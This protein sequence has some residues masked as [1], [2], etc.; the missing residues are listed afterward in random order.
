MSEQKP[1][2]A[3]RRWGAQGPRRK[4]R[5]FLQ[6]AAFIPVLW[7]VNVRPGNLALAFYLGLAAALLAILDLVMLLRGDLEY[8]HFQSRDASFRVNGVF[9]VMGLALLMAGLLGYLP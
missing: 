3:D 1:A 8:T 6:Y 5:T 2:S 4:V 9:F 7:A